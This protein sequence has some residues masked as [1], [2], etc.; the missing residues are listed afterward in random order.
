MGYYPEHERLE[1]KVRA[2][3]EL[4]QYI[5]TVVPIY[6]EH[7]NKGFTVIAGP[8]LS[9]RDRDAIAK[10]VTSHPTPPRV[11]QWWSVTHYSIYLYMDISYQVGTDGRTEHHQE[12]I[13][14]ADN[15]IDG[16]WSATVVFIPFRLFK[17][18][19]IKNRR[20]E[21][22]KIKEDIRDL[23]QKASSIM[24]EYQAFI[25]DIEGR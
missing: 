13:Y 15:S 14:V 20:F 1:I 24:E 19:E 4:R 16:T 7:L 11:R 2:V 18:Q 8:L 21:V 6:L 22:S 5:N 10:I 23:Q 3:N 25:P 17:V 9:K 12:S